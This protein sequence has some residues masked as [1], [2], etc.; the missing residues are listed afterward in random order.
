MKRTVQGRRGMAPDLLSVRVV[1]VDRSRGSEKALTLGCRHTA[2]SMEEAQ[3]LISEPSWWGRW[4]RQGDPWG[5]DRRPDR[6]DDLAWSKAGT[7]GNTAVANMM[8]S[9]VTLNLFEMSM[10]RKGAR[11][12]HLQ[13]HNR[14]TTSRGSKP[15]HGRQSSS[16]TEMV[17]TEYTLDEINQGWDMRG[18]KNIQGVIRYE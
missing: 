7:P 10:M 3:P 2:A 12:V 5:R 9:D 1:A 15:L 4:G 11:R 13:Q 14:A 16:S 8:A 18:G 17:T 6:A